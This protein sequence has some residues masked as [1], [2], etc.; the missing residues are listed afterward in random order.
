MF[1]DKFLNS[2]NNL[3]QRTGIFT[4]FNGEAGIENII[5]ILIAFVL[6]YLAI[7]KKFEPLLLL[8]IAFGMFIVNIPG[9]YRI[10]F[11]EKGYIITD[12]LANIEVARG[13]EESLCKLF[14]VENLDA[15]KNLLENKS[16]DVTLIIGFMYQAGSL[17][18]SSETVIG[19]FGLF[20][21]IYKG[22]CPCP[23]PFCPNP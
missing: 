17:A 16:E 4:L 19:D 23:C 22:V 21:Y 18:I 7:V 12:T 10:L 3:W 8:P 11:G 2:I 13:N 5:M 6:V 20:Y 14:N 1:W 9:A 15:L